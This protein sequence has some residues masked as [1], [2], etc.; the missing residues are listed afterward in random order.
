MAIIA[1][2]VVILSLKDQRLHR[3]ASSLVS[4]S[5]ER[6]R[7]ELDNEAWW[8]GELLKP[9]SPFIGDAWTRY[10]P[11]HKNTSQRWHSVVRVNSEHGAGEPIVNDP[12]H[13]AGHLQIR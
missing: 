9:V 5:Q 11:V 10:L 4:I 7:T 2:C 6:Y 8:I 12:A 13:R 3:S 1:H